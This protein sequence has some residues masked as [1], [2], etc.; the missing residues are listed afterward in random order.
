MAINIHEMKKRL[1]AKRAELEKSL[2]DLTEARPPSEHIVEADTGPEDMED[3]AVDTV[4]KDQEQP[5]A[6][7]EQELLVEVQAA[8]KRIEDGTYGYCTVCGQPI[9]EKRLEAMPWATLC[10]KDEEQTERRNLS[11][12]ELY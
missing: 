1:E 7:N 6:A 3:I 12:D 9:P 11:R 2:A 10:V 8:L 4:E 5:V